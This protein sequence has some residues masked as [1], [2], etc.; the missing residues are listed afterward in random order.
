MYTN[1]KVG[2]LPTCLSGFFTYHSPD[3]N[4]APGTRYLK[5]VDVPT[6]TNSNCRY[7]LGNAVH[8]SNICAGLRQ[9]GKDA[10]QVKTG[11][12]VNLSPFF[13]CRLGITCDTF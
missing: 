3:E 2:S 1:L 5:K 10:C 7:F 12:T 6:M 13:H 4:G 9:G 8:N 11:Q